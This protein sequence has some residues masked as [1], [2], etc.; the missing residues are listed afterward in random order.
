MP[1]SRDRLIER[2]REHLEQRSYP[3][4]EAFVI[5]SLAGMC[6]FLV[7][8][9]L[10]TAGITSMPVR[11]AL[12]GLSGYLAF[13]ALLGV[14][15]AWKRQLEGIDLAPDA[16]DL[17]THTRLPSGA[18][19]SDSWVAS[20]G[21]DGGSWFD[22]FDEL[23]WIVL[24]LVAA[25]AGLV[26]V[27]SIVWSAPALLAEVLVDAFIVSRVSRHLAD[28]DRRDWTMSAIR[29]TWMPASVL[30]VAVVVG[31]WALQQAAPDAASIGPA[32]RALTER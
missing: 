29:R 18:E 6:A 10:L 11:Y 7:S 23:G 27:G 32:L 14:Y 4:L 19:G 8:F 1:P 15:I 21:N 28:S 24:V 25:V 2:L 22:G 12:S 3:R 26:A 20:K 30:I 17:A 9:A 13:L 31:G 5:V 16:L